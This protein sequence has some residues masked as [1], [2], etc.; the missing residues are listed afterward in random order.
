MENYKRYDAH[1]HIFTLKYML[2][3]VK[4]MLHDVLHGTYPWHDP[5]SKAF[6]ATLKSWED[7]K[8][9][10]RQLYELV[11][12]SAGTEEENLNF[13]QSEAKK[14]YPSDNLRIVPLM[15]DIFYMLAYPLYKDQDVVGAQ[16]MKTGFFDENQFQVCW[17][18][19]LDDLTSH[20]QSQNEKFKAIPH[21]SGT[22]NTTQILQIIEEERS[23]TTT[24]Q[25]RSSKKRSEDST[26]F[27]PTDGFNFHL[28]NLM[29]LEKRRKGELYPFVAID[30]RRPGMIDELLTGSFFRGSGRFYGVKLYPRMGYHPQS[31]PM[32]AV[33]HYCSDHNLPIIF[34]CGMGGFPPSEEWK[35]FDFGNPENFEPVVKKYPKLKIDFAHLGSSEK[36]L[37]WANTIVRLVNEN[38]HVY[39]DLACYTKMDELNKIWPLWEN[40]TKL[41][42]RLMFGTDFDVMYFTGKVT[43]QSYYTNF[44]SIFENELE[45]LMHNNPMEFLGLKSK[46]GYKH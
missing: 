40:N 1:C 12:A 2:K 32:D 44:Q 19:I 41:K 43:M 36:S 34:H 7:L 15:M 46:K 31:S 45:L 4:S 33:Y 8:D 5:H 21:L 25:F 9:F 22:D 23:V 11:H 42:T 13:L 26:C 30:P 20:I 27:Y 6:F 28:N 3:E 18:E 39:S 10:L 29:D 35:Y 17:N 24:L 37:E 14:A 16:P 38:D